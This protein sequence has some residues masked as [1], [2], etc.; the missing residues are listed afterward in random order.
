MDR[1]Y[2]HYA[3]RAKSAVSP[4]D[5]TVS[6]LGMMCAA[7]AEQADIVAFVGRGYGSNWPDPRTKNNGTRDSQSAPR[8]GF[9]PN[10]PTNSE[11]PR[12][13]GGA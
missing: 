1:D 10:F 8:D 3:A 4:T 13:R 2:T 7:A 11:N 6:M 9:G 12:L 5:R